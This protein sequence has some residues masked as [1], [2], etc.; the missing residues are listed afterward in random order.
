MTFYTRNDVTF[1]GHH[2]LQVISIVRL[3]IL[4][5]LLAVRYRVL[6]QSKLRKTK[7][8]VVTGLSEPRTE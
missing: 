5:A 8:N 7:Y 2:I 4:I 6:I 1:R 3:T